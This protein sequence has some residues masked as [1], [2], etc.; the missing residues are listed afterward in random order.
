MPFF[1]RFSYLFLPSSVAGSHF[2]GRALIMHWIDVVH[3]AMKVDQPR[4]AQMMADKNAQMVADK[5]AQMKAE[6]TNAQM[7]A[8]KQAQRANTN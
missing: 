2:T 3:W 8:D 6:R 5:N 4:Q 1:S 7:Q